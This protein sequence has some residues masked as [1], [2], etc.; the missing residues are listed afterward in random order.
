MTYQGHTHTVGSKGSGGIKTQVS[1]SKPHAQSAENCL[2]RE[3]FSRRRE[4][5]PKA[6]EDDMRRCVC[7]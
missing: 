3:G 5:H 4:R 6:E 2:L 7:V 1:L